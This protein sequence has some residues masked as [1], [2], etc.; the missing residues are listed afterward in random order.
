MI[1]GA[2]QPRARDQLFG[3]GVVRG[4]VGRHPQAGVDAPGLEPPVP[5]DELQPAVLDVDDRGHCL[6]QT[7][8]GR[9][10][11]IKTG[12]LPAKS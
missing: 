3:C 7:D 10:R 9:A 11:L 5:E 1:A 2:R 6:E 4:E 8:Q 12:Q